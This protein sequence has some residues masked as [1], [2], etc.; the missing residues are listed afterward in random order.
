MTRYEA[1]E[2][3]IARNKKWAARFG[4]E[5]PIVVNEINPITELLEYCLRALALPE[6]GKVVNAE[7]DGWSKLDKPAR[8]GNTTFA[9]R[10]SS[11]LVV[12]CAQRA[13]EYKLREAS[14]DPMPYRVVRDGDKVRFE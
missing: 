13:Y 1:I 3:R 11:R 10:V 6:D 12:E 4:P 8:V 2:Q 9:P 7:D 5:S 14:G